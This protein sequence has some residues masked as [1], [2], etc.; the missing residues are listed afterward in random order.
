MKVKLQRKPTVLAYYEIN[1]KYTRASQADNGPAFT[2]QNM[3]HEATYINPLPTKINPYY[4]K[5]FRSYRTENWLCIHWKDKAVN[6][7]QE[8]KNSCLLW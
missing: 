8:K 4:I 3:G 2:W 7:V 1:T 6:S 5:R